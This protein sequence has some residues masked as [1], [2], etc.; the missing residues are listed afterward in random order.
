VQCVPSHQQRDALL[1]DLKLRATCVHSL[2]Q[3]TPCRHEVCTLPQPVWM[4]AGLR[5]GK[6][7]CRRRAV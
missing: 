6:Q 7:A 4:H 3:L 2:T 5:D 1:P